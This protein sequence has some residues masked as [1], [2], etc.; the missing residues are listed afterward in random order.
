M[1][2]GRSIIV[3]DF[4]TLAT[5]RKESKGLFWFGQAA[6][7]SECMRS[8]W[9]KYAS[10]L[11]DGTKPD[12]GQASGARVVSTASPKNFD[13]VKSLGADAVFDY[14]DSDVVK[15]IKDWA[16]DKPISGGVE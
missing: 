1:N 3:L 8:S 4:H 10:S 7:Q 13:L 15:K 2:A 14:R 11:Y 16:G 12:H 6:L 9:P 5:K